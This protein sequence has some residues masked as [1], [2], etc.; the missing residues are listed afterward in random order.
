MRWLG[1]LDMVCASESGWDSSILETFEIGDGVFIGAQAYIQGRFPGD[2]TTKI[3]NHVWIGP[4][5]YF[6]ARSFDRWRL[7]RGWARCAAGARLCSHR[8][9]RSTGQLSKPTSRSDPYELKSGPMSGAGDDSAAWRLRRKGQHRRRGRC[10]RRGTFHRLRS[11]PASRH[12]LCVGG[13][14][15]TVERKEEA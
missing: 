14:D 11:S 2:G 3:G 6:D 15:M 4:Q 13:M 9:F 1:D 7:R 12:G 8:T 5:A 10:G